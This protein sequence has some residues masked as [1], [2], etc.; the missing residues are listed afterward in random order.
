[1]T[2]ERLLADLV[3]VDFSELLPGP[4]FT[5]N[6]VELGARVIKVER[7]GGDNARALGPGLFA[8]VNRGKEHVTA[9]LRDD[10]DRHRVAELVAT[11]DVVVEGFRPRVLERLG[12]GPERLT[13]RHPQLIYVSLSGFGQHGPLSEEP[14]HDNTYAAYAGVLSLAGRPGGPPEWGPGVP[15]ADLCAA[16]YA[17][18]ATLAALRHRDRTGRGVRVDVSI[19]DCLAHWLNPRLGGFAHNGLS[20]VSEQRAS[21]LNRPGYGTFACADGTA[22]A[23][24]AIEDHFWAGLVR[25]LGLA[26]WTDPRWARHAARRAATTEINAAIADAVRNRDG[27]TVVAELS[28]CGV[29]VAPVLGPDDALDAAEAEGGGRVFRHPEAGRLYRFPVLFRS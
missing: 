16:M 9:D 8:A 26:E 14:G 12:F 15:V 18:S 29:P 10:A 5:Q 22:V 19:R 28:A 3:V 21:A 20:D 4:F 24:A 11:A 1:M 27:R 25:G 2:A 7:P 6:L 23:I 17:T 13:Q